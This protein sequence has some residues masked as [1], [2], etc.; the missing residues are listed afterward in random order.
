MGRQTDGLDFQSV[1]L[2][3]CPAGHGLAPA[4]R[5]TALAV[6]GGTMADHSQFSSPRPLALLDQFVDSLP[7]NVIL[8]FRLIQQSF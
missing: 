7:K 5:G 3:G 8:I 4:T 6:A 2:V 1:F